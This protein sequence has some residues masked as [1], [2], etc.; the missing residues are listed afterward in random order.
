MVTFV[1]FCS[2]S[3]TWPSVIQ[4]MPSREPPVPT[5]ELQAWI[6]R[7][8]PVLCTLQPDPRGPDAKANQGYYTQLVQML[9]L[10]KMVSPTH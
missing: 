8:R 10:K 2:H 7:T 6:K 1:D 9:T 5:P 4:L 3:H